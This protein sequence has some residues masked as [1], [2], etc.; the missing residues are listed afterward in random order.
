MKLNEKSEAIIKQLAAVT[1]VSFV[2]MG[3]A[4]FR[5]MCATPID[6]PRISGVSPSFTSNQV[7]NAFQTAL[8]AK[9]DDPYGKRSFVTSYVG[10]TTV[11]SARTI[12]T[13]APLS[14]GGDLS[15]N[16]TLS[17]TQAGSGTN[18]YLGSNDFT[19]FNGKVSSS[20]TINT[21]APITGG[22]DLSSDRTF[23]IAA[24]TASVDGYLTAANWLTF[25]AK[26][27]GSKYLTNLANISWVR[28][29][30]AMFDGTNLV[31]LAAGTSG[32]FLKSQGPS[33]DLAYAAIA[34][35]GDVLAANQ[36]SEFDPNLFRQT[37]GL[38]I[39]TNIQAYSSLLKSFSTN[40][41]APGDIFIIDANT[42]V[43]RMALPESIVTYS[44]TN[45]TI[46][47]TSSLNAYI[48]A[49]NS[50]RI[51]TIN[52][53]RKGFT[54]GLRIVS[55]TGNNAWSYTGAL[56]FTSA[57]TISTNNNSTNFV[58]MYCYDGTNFI[59]SSLLKDLQ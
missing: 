49:T 17:M 36:G 52:G 58:S 29:D 26:Q 45:V 34:G 3:L 12:S 16:R 19:T 9:T 5:A 8:D 27:T 25:N 33:N 23:A 24:A 37:L 15:A 59:C 20:R 44:G 41:P 39:G 55:T 56:K 51:A 6:N 11:S 38:A 47:L 10:T 30:L 57:Q 28:G 46:D 31:R 14:G 13:T 7:G 43:I 50:F 2:I 21:T 22:G 40:S 54:Y 48:N 4:A 35:G 32:Y 42:N 1:V 53:A 18:G